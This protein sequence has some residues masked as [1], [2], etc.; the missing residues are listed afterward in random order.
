[1]VA[2]AGRGESA[3]LPAAFAYP[4]V[5]NREQWK[6]LPFHLHPTR[7]SWN[8]V[9]KWFVGG[10]SYAI[11]KNIYHRRPTWVPGSVGLR[12]VNGSCVMEGALTATKL[13]VNGTKQ[14]FLFSGQQVKN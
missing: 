6:E 7:Y 1:M 3:L 11:P 14:R 13:N 10:G 12:P 8:S 4:V 2:A 9:Q 5:A